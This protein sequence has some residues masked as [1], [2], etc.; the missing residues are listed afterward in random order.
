MLVGLRG[1][2][3]QISWTLNGLLPDESR[4]YTAGN[5]FVYSGVYRYRIAHILTGG[6]LQAT[7]AGN[8]LPVGKYHLEYVYVLYSG[9]FAE[10]D[11]D[12]S[13]NKG[14][15]V[16]YNTLLYEFV[17]EH[18]AGSWDNDDVKQASMKFGRVKFRDAFELTEDSSRVTGDSFVGESIVT[19]IGSDGLSA[20]EL[21]VMHG[22]EGSESEY[23][24]QYKNAVT[25]VRENISSLQGQ[26][27]DL[28]EGVSANTEAIGNNAEAITEE[29]ERAT[30]A[31]A[32]LQE[33]INNSVSAIG[34]L[35][36]S[37]D[38]ESDGITLTLNKKTGTPSSIKLP[39]YDIENPVPAGLVNEVLI[40]DI[41]SW[42][43]ANAEAIEVHDKRLDAVEKRVVYMSESDYA[44]LVS[45]G[46]V[47]DNVEYNLYED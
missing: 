8:E 31:E 29:V 39:A 47:D 11:E 1:N 36:L 19:A 33:G 26:I 6:I 15:V 10:F 17:K 9:S 37:E 13:Y 27:N 38:N 34:D 4:D 16:R 14:D 44:K 5:F 46:N 43:D 3:L 42:S 20:Y 28:N 41:K 21:S 35:G 7:I 2:N 40:E 12:V 23:V 32:I 22:F 25:V 18:P 30:A 24:N 45:D